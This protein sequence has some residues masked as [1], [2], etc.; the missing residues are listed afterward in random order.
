MKINIIL[1]EHLQR[2]DFWIQIFLTHVCGSRTLQSGA[3]LNLKIV[4]SPSLKG[5]GPTYS[6]RTHNNGS[7]KSIQQILAVA[8]K[9]GPYA[10]NPNKIYSFLPDLRT[11]TLR[12]PPSSLSPVFAIV[13]LYCISVC[14]ISDWPHSRP[15]RYLK[16]TTK[17]ISTYFLS[18]RYI[19]SRLNF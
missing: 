4:N 14:F 7:K 12:L 10:D 15:P 13:T 17:L 11:V 16:I 3:I 5:P 19:H 1:F 2:Q 6:G 9:N 18:A 8:G